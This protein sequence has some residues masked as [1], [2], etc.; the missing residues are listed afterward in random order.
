MINEKEWNKLSDESKWNLYNGQEINNKEYNS[1][2]CRCDWGES[3]FEYINPL[4]KKQAMYFDKDGLQIDVFSTEV[5]P[6]THYNQKSYWQKVDEFGDLKIGDFVRFWDD[7]SNKKQINLKGIV[8]KIKSSEVYYYYFRKLYANTY[9]VD[10]RMQE[11]D[12]WKN[13]EK[14]VMVE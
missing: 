8:Y 4:N 10:G 13:V 11:I 14:A 12:C 7:A 9:I 6:N 1:D 2:E 5:H 3:Y